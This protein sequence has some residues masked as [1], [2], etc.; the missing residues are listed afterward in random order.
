M[1]QTTCAGK[2][3]SPDRA[4]DISEQAPCLDQDCLSP[5]EREV[6]RCVAF[7]MRNAEVA[8]T[9]SISEETVK[10][11]LYK[12]FRKVGVRSRRELAGYALRVGI[13]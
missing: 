12:I 6:T 13:V 4:M 10:V 7:G 8:R 5:R 3:P 2:P 1:R 9:L 11:H